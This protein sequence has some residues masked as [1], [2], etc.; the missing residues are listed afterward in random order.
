MITK[1]LLYVFTQ[2]FFYTLDLLGQYDN[3]KTVKSLNLGLNMQ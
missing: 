2:I 1:T 3:L